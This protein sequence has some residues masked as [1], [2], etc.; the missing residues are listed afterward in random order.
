MFS[1]CHCWNRTPQGRGGCM[2][3]TRRNWT[4]VTIAGN[5][6]WKQFGIARSMQ[7]S[8]NRVTYQAS[9][10]WCLGKNIQRKRIPGSQP[11]RSSTLESLLACSTRTT[12]TSWQRLLLQSIPHHQWLD[13]PSLSSGN[14]DNQ[15]DALRSAPSRA[16]RRAKQGHKKE[17]T[18]RN[19]SQFSFLK[20]PEAGRWPEICLPGAG[21]VGSLHW[22]FHHC[23]S[24][25]V[26]RGLSPW[27]KKYCGA[28]ISSLSFAVR[29]R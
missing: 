10:T 24:I 29:F 1:M 26:V 2:R 28:C 12:L 13:L 18:R 27:R 6:R 3:R 5:T 11:Q 14:K 25:P 4:P 9:T 20:G 16:N 21:S 17:V 19:P 7:E 15:Q 23:S 22:Q 8:Q